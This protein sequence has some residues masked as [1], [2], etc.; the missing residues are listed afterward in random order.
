[1]KMKPATTRSRGGVGRCRAFPCAPALLCRVASIGLILLS[2]AAC[3]P[4]TLGDRVAALEPLLTAPAT[5][6]VDRTTRDDRS[7]KGAPVSVVE[8]RFN[9]L[10][11]IS[12]LRDYYDDLLIT[13]HRYS[14]TVNISTPTAIHVEYAT[15]D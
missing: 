14:Q 8:L 15:R 1:M 2:A 13:Q 6:P 7:Q 3:R 4:P 11:P 9:S 10:R 5:T 12:P